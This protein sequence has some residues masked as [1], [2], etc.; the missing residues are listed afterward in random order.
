MARKNAGQTIRKSLHG[1]FRDPLKTAG[2]THSDGLPHD[3]RQIEASR[4]YQHP[5]QN[6]TLASEMNPSH[7][8]RF[9]HVGDASF[10][11]FRP[12]SL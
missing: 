2:L 12:F 8:A 5:F 7:A 10:R 9:V 4:V 1:G 11:Q 3:Q 6:V